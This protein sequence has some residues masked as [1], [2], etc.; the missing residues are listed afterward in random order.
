MTRR[1]LVSGLAGLLVVLVAGLL[2]GPGADGVAEP[3]EEMAAAPA[4]DD[5]ALMARFE[6]LRANGNSNCSA[7]FAASIATMLPVRL[8]NGSCC[9]PMDAHRYA[10]QVAALREYAGVPQIPPDPYSVP[11]GLA[12]ELM[13]YYAAE[14]TAAEQVA[15]DYA[16]AN[17]D[18]GGPC[19][20]RCWRWTVYG[21][22]A[23][24]LIR[25]RGFSGEQ[26]VEVWNL[27]SG[28]GG[29]AEHVHA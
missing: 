3:M 19:C 26:I 25:E 6:Y 11:A 14:L 24:Y 8:I 28:C 27:S 29:G 7:A 23:K 20:C 5:A 16:M 13:T 15:Y 22:L 18:E 12:R 9:S 1:T 2:A 17:S 21:G 10:E 4:A